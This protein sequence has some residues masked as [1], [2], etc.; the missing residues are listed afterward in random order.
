MVCVLVYVV[1][2]L[3]IRRPP[4]STRTDTLF[5]YTTLFR[6]TPERSPDESDLPVMRL[7]DAGDR[8][9]ARDVGR[10]AGNGDSILEAADELHQVLTN[11][12]LGSR[13]TRH[14][15]VGRITDHCPH[16]L[17]AHA[18]QGCFVRS[19]SDQRIGVELPVARAE[20]HT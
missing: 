14:Q 11:L 15:G 17:L 4:R 19:R 18:D 10:E 12:R 3:R 7:S 6:S 13:R 9:Q 8:L 20:E 5:P 16:P 2:F 1:F